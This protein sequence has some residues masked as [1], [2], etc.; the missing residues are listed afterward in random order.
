MERWAASN[1]E[2]RTEADLKFHRT[3]CH[4]TGNEA[5]ARSLVLARRQHPDVDHVRRS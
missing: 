4:L 3:M 2:D 1:L 5:A